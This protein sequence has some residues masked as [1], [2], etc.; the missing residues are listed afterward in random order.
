MG[1]TDRKALGGQVIVFND[2]FKSD[3]FE[4]TIT[5]V[6]KIVKDKISVAFIEDFVS[7]EGE[8]AWKMWVNKEEGVNETKSYSIL[9]RDQ[10]EQLVLDCV[11]KNKIYAEYGNDE[12]GIF[13]VN[14]LVN[15]ET[16]DD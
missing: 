9:P 3:A 2:S 12:E 6:N 1:L 13:Q 4:E 8:F 15:E 16:D 11:E 5:A 7:D 10:V 14:F